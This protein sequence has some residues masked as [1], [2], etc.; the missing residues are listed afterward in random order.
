MPYH[1]A[2]VN[3]A[4]MIA[5]LDSPVMKD[6]VDNL[7]RINAVADS[8]S[9]FVWRLKGDGNDATSLRPYDDDRIIVNMSVWESIDALFKY[10]YYSD[11]TDIF[12][13]RA[14]WFIKMTTPAVALWW[15]EE[16]H[17]PTVAEAQEKLALIEQHGPTPQAFTFKQ[18][19]TVEEMMAAQPQ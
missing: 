12:R 4:R 5:S 7:D 15:V 13:R 11:H 9:G 6:F 18:R 2:Q 16:G 10:A 19:F 1:I 3:I 17:I 8:A 14:E